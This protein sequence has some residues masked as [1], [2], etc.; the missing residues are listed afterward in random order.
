[1]HLAE[2]RGGRGG[3]GTGC[4][5]PAP[6][7]L[8]TAWSSP[9]LPTALGQHQ[10]AVSI[11]WLALQM[12]TQLG[13][14]AGHP[15]QGSNYLKHHL[16]PL[17]CR[18]VGSWDREPG[19]GIRPSA[20]TD[21]GTCSCPAAPFVSPAAREA[22]WLP[23]V[24]TRRGGVSAS[25]AQGAELPW[26]EGHLARVGVPREAGA[27]GKRFSCAPPSTCLGSLRTQRLA[28]W[29]SSPSAVGVPVPG[30]GRRR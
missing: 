23:A 6:P 17:R 27:A 28:L 20:Q 12:P 2:I 14:G 9:P 19:S 7:T 26:R 29:R 11:C 8:S 16:L 10:W 15:V 4:Q 1:M 5:L 13:L 3:L 24:P 18:A 25:S 30:P 21:T 22:P